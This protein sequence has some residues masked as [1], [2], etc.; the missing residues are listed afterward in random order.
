MC[1]HPSISHLE[2]FSPRHSCSTPLPLSMCTIPPSIMMFDEPSTSAAAAAMSSE[3]SEFVLW[4]LTHPWGTPCVAF[5]IDWR[6]DEP[7]LGMLVNVDI[8]KSLWCQHQQ[9]NKR[10]TL[11]KMGSCRGGSGASPNMQRPLQRQRKPASYK[12]VVRRPT[13]YF[14]S[15]D[16]KRLRAYYFFFLPQKNLIG[17]NLFRLRQRWV[18]VKA[19]RA[20]IKMYI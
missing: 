3:L 2:T 7:S 19:A 20:R 17:P 18:W 13:R 4:W 5:R 16:R 14:T 6:A 11:I 1:S 15:T 12:E 9:L 8:V 10:G